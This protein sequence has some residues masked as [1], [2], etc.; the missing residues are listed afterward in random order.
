[1]GGGV[2]NNEVFAI[3]LGVN[4]NVLAPIDK[5]I[6]IITEAN[7]VPFTY[8]VLYYPTQKI[9]L[10]TGISGSFEYWLSLV[11]IN[12]EVNIMVAQLLAY[13]RSEL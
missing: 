1:M 4:I 5:G 2:T 6:L 11:L 12:C 7:I 9:L 8:R 10:R 13:W 3:S